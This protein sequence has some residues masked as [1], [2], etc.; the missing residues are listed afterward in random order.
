MACDQRTSG[1]SIHEGPILLGLLLSGA[2]GIPATRLSR[3]FVPSSLNWARLNEWLMS[4]DILFANIHCDVV[5]E[6]PEDY[7]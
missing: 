5:D 2:R 6:L 3:L 4:P 7:M 1:V